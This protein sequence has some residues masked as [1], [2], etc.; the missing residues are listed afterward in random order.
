VVS[1]SYWQRIKADMTLANDMLQ[2]VLMCGDYS[3][4]T[5]TLGDILGQLYRSR[6]GAVV[7][8][9][10]ACGERM[11]QHR[12][13]VYAGLVCG[14]ESPLTKKPLSR[15]LEQRGLLSVS[16]RELIEQRGLSEDAD[17][18]RKI[19]LARG[20]V[21]PNDLHDAIRC[22]ARAFIEELCTFEEGSICVLPTRHMSNVALR[23]G[24]MAASEFLSGLRRW[25]DRFTDLGVAGAMAHDHMLIVAGFAA[26]GH[27]ADGSTL[28]N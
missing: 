11:R 21:D 16:A 8:V 23:T 6:T 1:A 27:G 13:Y 15:L 17:G 9:R 25:R 20:L 19:L 5:T 26:L 12:L 24:P 10:E 4:A 18:T 28:I 7:E 22:Y 2:H 3:L 14:I